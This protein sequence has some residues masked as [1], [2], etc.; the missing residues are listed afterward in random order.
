MELRPDLSI[1][2]Q[3]LAE[4]CSRHNVRTLALFGSA[5]GDAFN[6]ESDIDLLVEFEAYRPVGLMEV[7]Q[8]ELELSA[9]LKSREVEVRTPNDLSPLFRDEVRSQAR[10]LYAAA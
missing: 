1:D 2:D 3:A 5:L 4:L 10:S 6:D 9:L 7:A 8:F